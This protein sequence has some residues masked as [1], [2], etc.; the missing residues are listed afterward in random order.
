MKNQPRRITK[1]VKCLLNNRNRAGVWAG[2][3]R[4]AGGGAGAG[5]EAGECELAAGE[6]TTI[7][8]TKQADDGEKKETQKQQIAR[9]T[10]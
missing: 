7:N 8:V 2:A 6:T 5:A 10:H 1:P 4:G 9:G 3:V